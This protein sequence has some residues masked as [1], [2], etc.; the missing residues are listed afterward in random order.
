M[1]LDTEILT[2]RGW[3]RHDEVRIGD[4]TLGYDS[5]TQT[6]RWTRV[7]E[8]VCYDSA[9]LTRLGGGQSWSLVATP[10]HRLP[11]WR[12]TGRTGSRWEK[13]EYTTPESLK[14][15][16]KIV[17]SAPAITERV[18]DITA[19]EA[20]IVGWLITDGCV[21]W[22]RATGRTSQA[23]GS[24]RGNRAVIYQAKPAGRDAVER[25][26][27]DIPHTVDVRAPRRPGWL[28]E[29]AY[30]LAP[31]WVRSL[32]SRA[33]LF[34]YSLERWVLLLDPDQRAAF[35]R[36]ACL[37]EGSQSPCGV[38]AVGQN[39]GDKQRAI[40]LAAHLEGYDVRVRRH[41]AD[42]RATAAHVSM[43]L[44]R[45]HVT[46]QRLRRTNAGHG[47][48]WCVRTE[49]KTWTMRQR[50]QIMLTSNTLY[51]AGPKRL[52]T[53]LG[54]ASTEEA[55]SIIDGFFGAY[56]ALE[57][58]IRATQR[59]TE[60]ISLSG[61]RTAIDPDKAYASTNY[62]IQGTARDLFADALL[63]LRAAGW[64]DAL[65]L[66]IHDEI[67][68]QVPQD[69]ADAARAALEHAMTCVFRDIPITARATVLGP[70]WGQ[71]PTEHTPSDEKHEKAEGH[72]GHERG[73]RR[74]A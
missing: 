43:L 44:A 62:H 48:V 72:E 29:H 58:Y 22:A 19:D 37:A 70:R 65:W 54:L 21:Q 27:K 67:I 41:V 13:F 73:E 2:R 32:W 10:N 45:G 7:L 5:Q 3:L 30:A 64:G 15:E 25:L 11:A 23:R 8:V 14:S 6:A 16:H 47:P 4:E 49:L 9:P 56:P 36:A 68:M 17:L 55:R 35:V 46:G 39:V 53:T 20:G 66:V 42:S 34:E 60:I 12:R 33:R 59:D 51:G 69:R 26:L 57:S 31:D 40:Q 50:D 18:L 38:W 61:R 71:L 63:R 24:R 1:P 52:A 28:P 74:A